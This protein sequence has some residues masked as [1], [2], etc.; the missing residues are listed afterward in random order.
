MDSCSIGSV[1]LD[2]M[3]SYKILLPNSLECRTLTK[4]VTFCSSNSC[5]MTFTGLSKDRC[6]ELLG[7]L[8]NCAFSN[9]RACS[10]PETYLARAAEK[11]TSSENH[12]QKVT[13][14]GASNM[15]RVKQFFNDKEIVF[16]DVSVPGWTPTSENIKAFVELVENKNSVS[17]GFVF[18]LLGNS[19]VRFEQFDGSTAMP[20]KSGGIFHLGRRVTPTP[21]GNFRKIIELVLPIFKAKGNK[22]CAIVPPMPRYLFSRCCMDSGHCTN[23]NEK[24]FPEKMLSGFLNLR[25]ELIRYL[26]Q[27]GLTD[28]KVLDLCCN[29]GC[30]TTA[31]VPE[32]LSELKQ[33]TAKDGVH[34]NATG[35]AHL[36]G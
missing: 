9:F 13:L 3:E 11:N 25:N 30:A 27:H 32:R 18:D 31:S 28:F 26:V 34:L 14:V 20:F 16:E 12:S 33:A 15:Q 2:V 35:Y 22:P 24:D 21:L 4:P 6:S 7:C 23:M 19:S 10:R 1:T 8:L 36:A 29:T 17:A 5:P